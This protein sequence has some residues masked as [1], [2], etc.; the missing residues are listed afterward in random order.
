[1]HFARHQTAAKGRKPETAGLFADKA[2]DFERRTDRDFVLHDGADR[3]KGAD[4]AHR[5]VV[6]AA[7]NDRVEMGAGQDPGR[8]ALA[9]FEPTEYIA[10]AVDVNFQTGLAHE[11]N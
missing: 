4:H 10:H 6:F 8:M 5:S 11:M 1:M 7:V 2:N 9:A 3:L